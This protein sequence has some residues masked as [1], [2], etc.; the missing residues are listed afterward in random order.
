MNKDQI[1][2]KAKSTVGN[3]EEQAGY[4]SDDKKTEAKGVILQVKGATQETYGD[5]KEAVGDAL[6]DLGSKKEV[7]ASDSKKNKR[8]SA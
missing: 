1:K 5:L 4:W 3:I 7:A 8:K 2:G 6:E